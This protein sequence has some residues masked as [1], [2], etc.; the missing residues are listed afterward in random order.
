[1]RYL[2]V[3]GCIKG[4]QHIFYHVTNVGAMQLERIL[5]LERRGSRL[6]HEV[7]ARGRC[8]LESNLEEH[9]M[10]I[11]NMTLAEVPYHLQRHRVGVLENIG[12]F[13]RKIP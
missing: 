5:V 6:I 13:L 11:P 2:N 8:D 10:R 9:T 7:E 4:S 12:C 1:M 3:F